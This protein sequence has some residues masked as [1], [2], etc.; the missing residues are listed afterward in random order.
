MAEQVY[1]DNFY[2]NRN[3]DTEYAAVKILGSTFER[4][5]FEADSMVDVGCGVGTWLRVAR[6]KHNVNTIV[7]LDGDYVPRQYLQIEGSCFIPSNLENYRVDKILEKLEGKRKFDIAVC[8]E[9]AEHIK[10]KGARGFI[11]KLCRLSDMVIFS[12]A[13][14]GQGGVAHVNEQRLSYWVDLFEKNNYQLYDI[15]R[16][17]IWNDKNIPVWYRNNVVIFCN[18]EADKM[19]DT[20]NVS[21]IVDMVCPDMFEIKINSYEKQIRMMQK[22]MNL[23]YLL[24]GEV[25]KLLE[26]IKNFVAMNEGYR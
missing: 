26:K 18:K 2:K 14:P 5:R 13:V 17:D 9:V 3:K 6:D 15:I 4:L 16:A 19:L 11:D 24:K 21:T 8:L 1:N 23:K 20:D 10:R 7:G 25:C 12:A 22:N